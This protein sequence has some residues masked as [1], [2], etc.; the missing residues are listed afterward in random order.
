MREKEK[1]RERE[2]S[3]EPLQHTLSLITQ[4]EHGFRYKEIVE[5]FATGP[6]S[7]NKQQKAAKDGLRNLINIRELGALRSVLPLTLNSP[8]EQLRYSE[9]GWRL[10]ISVRTEQRWRGVED[11]NGCSPL[12]RILEAK[13]RRPP[14]S[15]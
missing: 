2:L 6:E 8:T 10:S 7:L 14:R 15:R 11:I 1:D 13:K 3:R 9:Q 12:L 4:E 5:L